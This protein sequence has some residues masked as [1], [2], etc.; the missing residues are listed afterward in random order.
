MLSATLAGWIEYKK[1][2]ADSNVGRKALIAMPF[3]KADLDEKWLPGLRNA[4]M[5]T[6]YELERVD[7]KPE[8]GLI[9]TRMKLQIK[10]ARFLLVEL[11]H[12]NHGAY[13]EAGMAE[14]SV[15]SSV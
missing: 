7:D 14:E 8:P 3:G 15:R 13:W 11:T 6:G 9:D 12:S 2:L 5:Q 4:V 10:A 1:I